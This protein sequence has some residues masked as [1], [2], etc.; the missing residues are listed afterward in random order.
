MTR[1]TKSGRA[2]FVGAVAVLAWAFASEWVGN[3]ATLW[4]DGGAATPALATVSASPMSNVRTRAER[5]MLFEPNRGQAN[6]GA[7]Q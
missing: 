1:M 7:R 6:P 4:S 3:A 5:F 2:L